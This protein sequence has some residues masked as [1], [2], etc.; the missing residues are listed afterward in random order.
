MALADRSI[1]P[2]PHGPRCGVHKCLAKLPADDK[3]TLLAW[4]ADD[5]VEATA[6]ANNVMAEHP[7]LKLSQHMVRN[8]RKGTCSCDA[9]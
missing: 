9:R 3:A 2:T 5:E 8:H 4:L 1:A 6:I 7:A